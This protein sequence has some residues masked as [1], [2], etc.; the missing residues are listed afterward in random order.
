[1]KRS[2]PNLIHNLWTAPG[3]VP[4][5]CDGDISLCGVNLH[6]IVIVSVAEDDVGDPE[7]VYL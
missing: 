5:S 2:S 4:L 3:E 1:M 6:S 7:T